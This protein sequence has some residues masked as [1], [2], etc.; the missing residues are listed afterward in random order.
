MKRIEL[1]LADLR[2]LTEAFLVACPPPE[3]QEGEVAQMDPL[4]Q[5]ILDQAQAQIEHPAYTLE[6]EDAEA[7]RLGEALACVLEDISEE[8]DLMMIGHLGELL[9]RLD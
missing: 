4:L 6:L 7:E 2:L 3:S 1:D 8:G 9:S 5:K